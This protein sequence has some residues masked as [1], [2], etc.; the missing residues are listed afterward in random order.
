MKIGEIKMKK[1]AKILGF[2]FHLLKVKFHET[3]KTS[4]NS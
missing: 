4:Y 1:K 2:L 3:I